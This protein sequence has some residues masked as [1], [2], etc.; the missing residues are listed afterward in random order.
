MVILQLVANAVGA[1]ILT[2][3]TVA[4]KLYK[5]APDDNTTT[6][7]T[8]ANTAGTSVTST[9]T[10]SASSSTVTVNG[11][12]VSIVATDELSNVVSS[13]NN[14]NIGDV[15][16]TV[17]ETTGNLVLTSVS[18]ADITIKDTQAQLIVT[19]ME[20]V[21]STAQTLSIR[22]NREYYSERSNSL[23]NQDGSIIKLSGDNVSEI[24]AKLKFN[25]RSTIC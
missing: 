6:A 19:S 2:T 7:A 17:E 20:D 21:T 25:Y 22:I 13:I 1:G 9:D 23:I 24:G 3:D 14:A 11:N 12:A 18:G 8:T 5:W 4:L 15:R 16:A 10:T